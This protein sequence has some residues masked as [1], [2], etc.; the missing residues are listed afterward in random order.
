MVNNSEV[1]C[2]SS[3]PLMKSDKYC[4]TLVVIFVLGYKHLCSYFLQILKNGF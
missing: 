3:F 4:H 2:M 1:K